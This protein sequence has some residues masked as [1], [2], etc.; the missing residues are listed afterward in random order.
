LIVR[1]SLNIHAGELYICPN[2]KI[3]FSTLIDKHFSIDTYIGATNMTNTKYY[4]MVFANQLPD[5]Y[6]PAPKN[7]MVFGG[8]NLKYTF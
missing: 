1:F 2:G 4:L 3:G 5:A 6:L 7:A 8:I